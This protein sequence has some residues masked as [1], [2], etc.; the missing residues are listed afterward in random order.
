MHNPW[1]L[2]TSNDKMFENFLCGVAISNTEIVHGSKSFTNYVNDN[3]INPDQFIDGRYS[4]GYR[5]IK[6]DK[7]EVLTD[8][9]GQDIIFYFHE[10]DYWVLSNSMAAVIDQL[11]KDGKEIHPN[12]DALKTMTANGSWGSHPLS[13]S[14]ICHG[15][16][17]LPRNMKVQ[18]ELKSKY[19]SIMPRELKSFSFRDFEKANPSEILQQWISRW[20][21]LYH[22]IKEENYNIKVDLTGGRDSRA[23]F[24]SLIA[25]NIN[26]ADLA[27]ISQE[28]HQLDY[29]IADSIAKNFNLSLN[30]TTKTTKATKATRRIN[31]SEDYAYE[32]WRRGNMGIYKPVYPI[33][34]RT[35][36]P[37]YHLH[38]GGGE[39]FRLL[40]DSTTETIK[41]NN[42][43]H[44]GMATSLAVDK[45]L[46][47]GMAEFNILPENEM[48]LDRHYCE[49][50]NRFHYGRA[51]YRN[52]MG[53]LLTPLSSIELNQVIGRREISSNSGDVL[54]AS[55]LAL[56][57]EFLVDTPFDKPEKNFTPEV[58][59]IANEIA[60]SVK[61]ERNDFKIYNDESLYDGESLQQRYTSPSKFHDLFSEKLNE[62]NKNHLSS[63][64]G[65]DYVDKALSENND[66]SKEFTKRSANA[67]ICIA[68]ADFF[69]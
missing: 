12:F 15:V 20:A 44:V 13:N 65:K 3:G 33:M 10:F 59:R 60:D 38:G 52:L 69:N 16:K 57:S 1:F 18:I 54:L 67:S 68:V 4:L 53:T 25:S 5:R 55:I 39:L 63:F 64:L 43:R 35:L 22:A 32:L 45:S 24:S 42:I 7:F 40:Y 8:P 37:D 11:K 47:L 61:I 34:A 17:I 31:Y 6:E 51:W 36:T 66:Q 41:K 30:N 49:Y 27:I 2:L 21:S 56:G 19:F 26:L 28:R 50:R 14:L 9:M 58:K 62:L 23:V 46:K 48:A 29:K